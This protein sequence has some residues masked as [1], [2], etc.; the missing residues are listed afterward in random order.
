MGKDNSYTDTGSGTDT[1]TKTGTGIANATA[2]KTTINNNN[3]ATSTSTTT[4]TI[5]TKYNN[6]HPFHSLESRG[7]VSIK[8][9][10]QCM[11]YCSKTMRKDHH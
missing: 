11:D 1:D 2:T 9:K 4:D 5:I 10:S 6:S 7:H 3:T 8:S